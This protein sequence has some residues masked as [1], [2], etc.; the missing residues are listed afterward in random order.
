MLAVFH[1]RRWDGDFLTLR[2]LIEEGGRRGSPASSPASSA[3]GRGQSRTWREQ[4][5]ED[6]GGVST[7]WART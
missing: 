7:T 1:N 5:A 3:G 6:A 2:R 4:P